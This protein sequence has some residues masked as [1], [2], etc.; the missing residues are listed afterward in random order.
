[1]CLTTAR[2][3]L[4]RKAERRLTHAVKDNAEVEA[5]A[6]FLCESKPSAEA[7][8]LLLTQAEQSEDIDSSLEPLLAFEFPKTLNEELLSDNE[9][10]WILRYQY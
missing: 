5:T 8:Q 3:N 1:V 4:R 7:T 10:I 9:G 2:R 6:K